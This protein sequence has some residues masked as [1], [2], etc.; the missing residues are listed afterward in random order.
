MKP[1]P[2]R[3]NRSRAKS[4]G[5][6]Q[7]NSRPLIVNRPLV[8]RLAQF[9]EGAVAAARVHRILLLLTQRVQRDAEWGEIAERDVARLALREALDALAEGGDAEVALLA[10]VVLEPDVEV[11]R[12]ERL[13]I[14]LPRSTCE[15]SGV[16]DRQ[17]QQHVRRIG[18]S[19][20]PG[21]T[22]PHDRVVGEVPGQVR[23]RQ[24]VLVVRLVL[25][26]IDR[27]RTLEP[28]GR[29]ALP[30]SAQ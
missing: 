28:S 2:P 20:G 21:Q 29:V 6:T 14:G 11:V 19:H 25:D 26:V 10:R 27:V 9:H 12:Q 23:G 15:T 22:G 13:E 7:L 1:S 3:P 16:A 18:A 5:C 17:A 30:E 24:P 8:H 4:S